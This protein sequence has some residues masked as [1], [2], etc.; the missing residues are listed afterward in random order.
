MIAKFKPTWMIPAIYNISPEKLQSNGIKAIF[1]DLDNT[2]IPWNNPDGTP[3]LRQWIKQLEASE[4]TLVVISNNKHT[5]VKRAL[6]NLHLNFIARSCKPLSR[7]IKKA[8]KE[9]HL[10]PNEVIMVGDQLLT[11][12][13]A[14]NNAQVKS[15]LVKPLITSDSWITKPNRMLEILIWKIM[16]HKYHGLHWQEDINDRK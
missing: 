4:I 6:N 10:N 7:G 1:S 13:W 2:L 11:D 5:R 16:M 14:A 12:I 9:Y 15:V 3:Q 8:L